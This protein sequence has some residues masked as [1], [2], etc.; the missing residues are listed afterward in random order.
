MNQDINEIENKIQ[1]L[2][3]LSIILG[4]IPIFIAIILLSLLQVFDK[5]QTIQHSIVLIIWVELIDLP[6]ISIAI[7][8]KSLIMSKKI[9]IKN[10]KFHIAISL[11]IIHYIV[12]GVFFFFVNGLNKMYK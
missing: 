3:N 8:I 7:A 5:V 11:M 12:Y 4:S 2:N 10:D 6:I 9:K 1:K